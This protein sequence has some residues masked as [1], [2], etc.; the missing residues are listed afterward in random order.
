M[1]RESRIRAGVLSTSYE[2]K[3]LTLDA[4]GD[5]FLV[6]IDLALPADMM[7]DEYL[8]EV[9]RWIQSS[10]Q[11]RHA[12]VVQGVYWRR[13]AVHDQR[14]IALKAAVAAQTQRLATLDNPTAIPV[15]V[16]TPSGGLAQ[17]VARDELDAFRRALQTPAIPAHRL[18]TEA[19]VPP[20][21]SH[22]DFSALSDTQYGKL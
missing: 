15:P 11:K 5:G 14:G 20:P 3:V 2:F 18:D 21:E 9:E 22:S 12:M 7:P 19:D 13:K 1:V 16:L 17:P 10:A 8:L 6:L 4:N